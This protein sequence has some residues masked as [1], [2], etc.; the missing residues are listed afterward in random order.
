MEKLMIKYPF[1]ELLLISKYK[2]IFDEEK[3]L[4]YL[5]GYSAFKRDREQLEIIGSENLKNLESI[6]NG[7]YI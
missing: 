3:Y 6:R 1:S 4:D 7:L 5:L 2:I